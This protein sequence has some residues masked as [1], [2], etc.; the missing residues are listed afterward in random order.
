ME[1][2]VVLAVVLSLIVWYGYL[3]MF[4]PPPKPG[5]TSG[6]T[7][8]SAAP[9]ASPAQTSPAPSTTSTAPAPAPQ[10]PSPSA[11][12]AERP[13]SAPVVAA[14]AER[15][16]TFENESVRAIFTTR[17]GA[18]KSWRL[19]KYQDAAHQPLELVPNT[20]PP[21]TVRPF[22]L[23]VPDAS[24]SATLAQAQFKPSAES[25][26][27]SNGPATLAFEYQDA[28]G[29]AARKEFTF[30]PASPYVVDVTASVT[31]GGKELVPTIE[32]GP[33]IGS[34]LVASTRTYSP[35]PQ[36]I[37]YRD[38]SVS[39]IKNTKVAENAVQ[40]G[41]IGF[42]GVDD[43][44]F[45]AAVIP[46]GQ[47]VHV[48]YASLEVPLPQPPGTTA[49]Y[50]D[51]SVR[52]NGAPSHARFFLGPKDFDVLA[53][54]DR[55]LV[56]SIDFG[57]FAWLVVPLLRALKWVDSYVGNYGWSIIL[58]TILINVAMFPLR[59]KSVV[60]MRRMQ[61]LQPEVKAIQDRYANL[62]MTDP[63]KQKMNTELMSLYRERGVNPASGCVPML[64]TLP[65]LFAFYSMLSVAIE[66]RGAP[67]FGWIHDLSVHDP[68][69]ITPILMG[70]T[71]FVQTKMTPTTAD[72]MQQ[73]MMMFM[74]LVMMS[75]FL[76]A[77]SGLVLYWTTSNLWAIGQQVLTN[78]LIGPPA[79]RTVRPPAERRVKNVGGGKTDQAVKERK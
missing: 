78:R 49:H 19:K 71:Q 73:K 70:I 62:K 13:A 56:R 60:S 66:L 79:V 33:G 34:G 39:R 48:Q 35:P 6:E 24:V 53:A 43:H 7:G 16:I 77:P 22:T 44:Y 54:V 59:H 51:W 37:F 63:G 8:A 61:D 31:Q 36:P 69:Y 41:S 25:V 15:D 5:T 67:F 50:I 17:G 65:V 76:W 45:L 2:R 58:L 68:L 14:G 72:P 11:A 57:I 42:A 64:L 28:A 3:A 74:P 40:E 29:L 9:G 4:P 52:Y 18:L 10:A 23:T 47:P 55:D 32:W 75:F 21:G 27:A 26:Q 46:N 30:N 38:G 1:K 12:V 20:V